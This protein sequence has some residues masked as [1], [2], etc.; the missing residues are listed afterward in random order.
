MSGDTQH[1]ADQRGADD[2][3]AT[4]VRPNYQHKHTLVGHQGPVSSCKFADVVNSRVA[5]ASSDKLIKIWDAEEGTLMSTFEGHTAGL[6]DVCWQ[7]GSA[8]LC[9]AS[10]DKTLKLWDVEAGTCLRTLTGHTNYV[11]CCNFD[12]VAG[13]LLVRQIHQEH[14]SHIACSD[15]NVSH[16]LGPLT[17]SAA[18]SMRPCASG[19]CAAASACGSSPP[20]PT[21]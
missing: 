3:A 9:S 19:M 5:T 10:D 12:P 21:L 6:S 20:I 1:A 4:E 14:H 8:F 18:A 17:R 13:H 2:D 7:K 11:F 16:P 15:I